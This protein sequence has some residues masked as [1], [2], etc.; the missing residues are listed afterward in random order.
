MNF[1]DVW[2]VVQN[3]GDVAIYA[4]LYYAHNINSRVNALEYKHIHLRKWVE[5][6]DDKVESLKGGERGK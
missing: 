6:I 1:G 3:G 5:K 4:I 2:N